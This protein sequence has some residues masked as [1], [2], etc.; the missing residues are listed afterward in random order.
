M[1][2]GEAEMASLQ[3]EIH[4]LTTKEEVQVR[5][6][7][8]SAFKYQEKSSRSETGR[9][10]AEDKATFASGRGKVG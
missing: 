1:Q 5:D 7:D 4:T 6:T 8:F 10:Y 9:P 2:H 3:C